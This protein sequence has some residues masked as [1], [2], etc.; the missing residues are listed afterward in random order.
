MDSYLDWRSILRSTVVFF[1]YQLIKTCLTSNFDLKKREF[2]LPKDRSHTFL[3]LPRS[4]HV[5]GADRVHNLN[6]RGKRGNIVQVNTITKKS[7]KF[8]Q[9]L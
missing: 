1:R 6:I 7:V 4:A 2:F 5:N 3:L 8:S 9:I